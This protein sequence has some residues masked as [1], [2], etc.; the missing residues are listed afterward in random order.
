VVGQEGTDG[1][2]ALREVVKNSRIGTYGTQGE[3]R[4]GAVSGSPFL[5]S[6]GGLGSMC[7]H[8]ELKNNYTTSGEALNSVTWGLKHLWEGKFRSLKKGRVE[9]NLNSGGKLC[10]QV[11]GQ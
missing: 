2:L 5:R 10:R 6:V 1:P 11:G 8:P 3:N 4:R 9:K 7:P